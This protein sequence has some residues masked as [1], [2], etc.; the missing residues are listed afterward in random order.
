LA[1]PPFKQ[2]AGLFI[3]PFGDA[4]DLCVLH[5]IKI[6]TFGKVAAEHLILLFIAPAFLRVGG[7]AVIAFCPLSSEYGALHAGAVCKF[8][9][10]VDGDTLKD[11][12]EQGAVF[13]LQLV[14]CG[15]NSFFG[16]VGIFWVNSCRVC[17]SLAPANDCAH[18]AGNH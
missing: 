13:P 10:V 4:F 12:F 2:F 16:L 15:L 8:A 18:S 9:A 3:E 17:R 6:C 1:A 5:F 11:S 14:Q 7:V